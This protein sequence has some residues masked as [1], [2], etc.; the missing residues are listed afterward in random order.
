MVASVW[1]QLTE[2][3][4]FGY[5]CWCIVANILRGVASSR[6]ASVCD[7]VNSIFWRENMNAK[8]RIVRAFRPTFTFTLPF[9]KELAA[10]AQNYF[11]IKSQCGYYKI[12]GI[13]QLV[14]KTAA[15]A[16]EQTA[17]A[18]LASTTALPTMPPYPASAARTETKLQ[19]FILDCVSTT[20]ADNTNQVT[21][22][23]KIPHIQQFFRSF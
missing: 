17:V 23:K 2:S 7:H 21:V 9:V 18:T 14:F 20:T 11:K 4:H 15:L 5:K 6:F 1:G 8:N 19:Y 13:I 22:L 10:S 16:G 12:S 3:W